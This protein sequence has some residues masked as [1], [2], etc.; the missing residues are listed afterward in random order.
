MSGSEQTHHSDDSSKLSM[1]AAA[2]Y[3]SKGKAEIQA[4]EF[5]GAQR[6]L[7]RL[8]ADYPNH[9]EA[10]Y[11]TSVAQRFCENYE[12]ALSTLQKLIDI[13]PTYGRAWQERG[14]IFMARNDTRLEARSSLSTGGNT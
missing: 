14:H 12:G 13:E 6:L 1:E 5:V 7:E 10:L 11:F 9:S 8:L 2:D 4:G 3:L